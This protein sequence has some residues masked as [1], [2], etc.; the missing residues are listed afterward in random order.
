VEKVLR[1][2]DV[3]VVRGV[4]HEWINRAKEVA[5]VFAV[6]VPSLEIVVGDGKRLGKTEAG[7]IYDPKEE[8]D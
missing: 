5:R 3:V 7:P 4:N 2:H 6:V 8:E 1:E